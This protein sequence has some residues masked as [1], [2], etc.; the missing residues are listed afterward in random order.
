MAATSGGGATKV[1]CHCEP[2]TACGVG[3]ASAGGGWGSPHVLSSQAN[4]RTN[5]VKLEE[6]DFK[7][8][9][10]YLEEARNL[11]ASRMPV[12]LFALHTHCALGSGFN[13]Y[14]LPGRLD[15]ARVVSDADN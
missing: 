9:R 13:H 2:E 14:I 12:R 4:E 11:A 5:A 10:T 15:D 7:S 3:T 8:I 1:T 6:F